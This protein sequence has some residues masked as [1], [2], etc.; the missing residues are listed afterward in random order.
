MN[1]LCHALP[2]LDRPLLAAATGVPDWLSVVDRKIRARGKVASSFLASEEPA[3]RDVAAGIVR[4]VEDDRWFHATRAF[5]ETSLQL[6]V[7]LRDLLPGDAGFRPSF[8]GHILVEMLLDALWIRDDQAHAAAYFDAVASVPSRQIQDC[9]NIITG[10]PTDR[11]QPVIDRFVEIQFLYDYLDNA[12]LLARLNQ[13]MNRVGLNPLPPAVADWLSHA[14]AL[15][16][17]RRV[18]LL[19]PPTSLD[20]G[21]PSSNQPFPF[22]DQA[23]PFPTIESPF[24][25]RSSAEKNNR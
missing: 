23:F 25:S 7:E 16:E 17:S 13:V 8:V 9:V 12:K 22:A 10:K 11:L 4:H 1:F 14:S 24:R 3:L 18:E 2:Y 20:L 5:A 6:A 21:Q 15:V 19:T